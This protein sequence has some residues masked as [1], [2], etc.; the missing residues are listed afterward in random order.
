MRIVPFIVSKM[1]QVD[2]GTAFGK[3][4]IGGSQFDTLIGQPFLENVTLQ[5]LKRM[6]DVSKSLPTFFSFVVT[7]WGIVYP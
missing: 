1:T 7:G 4:T 5:S 2:T 6:I 3:D